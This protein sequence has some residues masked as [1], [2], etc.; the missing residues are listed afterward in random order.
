MNKE[1]ELNEEDERSC[2][3]LWSDCSDQRLCDNQATTNGEEQG[4]R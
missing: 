2:P 4:M 3:F 1:K